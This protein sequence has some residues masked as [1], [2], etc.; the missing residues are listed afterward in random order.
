L[1]L[2]TTTETDDL[3]RR[4]RGGDA[5][6]FRALVRQYSGDLYGLAYSLMGNAADAEDV[7]QQALVGAV[8][9]IGSF[10]GRS[11][12]K[13]WLFTILSNQAGKARRSR[14]L[15]QATP[16]GAAGEAAD[17]GAR[18]AARTTPADTRSPTGSADVRMDVAAMLDALAPD[19]R[20]VIVLREIEQLSYEEIAETL[21]IP[22][23]TVESR[24]FRARRFL[25]ERFP[26]YATHG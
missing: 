16:L 7:V 26:A 20:Q 1:Q 6:A 18:G 21:G 17:A 15:R 22:R 19:H 11:S 13:T 24:L 3:V 14:A 25:R 4:L 8:R 23:G 2:T 12:L 5:E 10:E 9:G